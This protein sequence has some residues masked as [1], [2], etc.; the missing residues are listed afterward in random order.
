MHLVSNQNVF[1]ILINGI[2]DYLKSSAA[3]TGKANSGEYLV[4]LKIYN[5]NG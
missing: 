3:L 5:Q 2:M 4:E 1:G